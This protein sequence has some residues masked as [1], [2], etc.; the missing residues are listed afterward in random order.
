VPLA[1]E[2]LGNGLCQRLEC[3]E[4]I[5]VRDTSRQAPLST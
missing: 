1:R 2:I 5:P 3:L 4:R